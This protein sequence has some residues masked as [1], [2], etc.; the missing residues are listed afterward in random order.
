MD[1]CGQDLQ[2]WH[3]P[4]FWKRSLLSVCCAQLPHTPGSLGGSSH[5]HAFPITILLPQKQEPKW[6]HPLLSCFCCVF[7]H[8]DGKVTRTKYRWTSECWGKIGKEHWEWA[9]NMELS[10][11]KPRQRWME[12]W[13]LGQTAPSQDGGSLCTFESLKERDED[14]DESLWEQ[15]HGRFVISPPHEKKWDLKV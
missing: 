8:S 12:R 3:F 15:W 7:S 6:A 13:S 4:F 9:L 1:H 5:H 14:I 11:K 10:F 2:G